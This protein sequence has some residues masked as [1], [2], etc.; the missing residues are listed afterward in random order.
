M[1]CLASPA[2]L[3]QTVADGVNSAQT[4]DQTLELA[5]MSVEASAQDESPQSYTI[6]RTRGATGLDLSPRQT[7]Q[8]VTSITRQQLDDQ[9]ITTIDQALLNT[10]GITVNQ[11]DI[12]MRNSYRARGYDIA[13]YRVDGLAFEGA[14][15]IS[16]SGTAIN[17]DLYE[18]IDIVRG[19]NGLL[20]GTGDP[21]ATIDLQRKR[22]TRDFG[23]SASLTYG[24]W[25]QKRV[26]GDINLPLSVDGS[27]RSRLVVS[28]EESDGFLDHQSNRSHG[29]LLNFEL[30]LSDRT[31]LGA[32]LQYEYN[33][34]AGATWG[35]NS[36]V[37]FSDGSMTKVSR[38]T[39]VVPSWSS[40]EVESRTLFASLQHAFE[41][42]WQA[43]LKLSRTDS[44]VANDI[45]IAKVNQIR[46]AT[47]GG[48]WN[49]DGSGAYMNGF[50]SEPETVSETM[51][52]RFTGPFELL[53]REHQ[54]MIGYNSTWTTETSPQFDCSFGGVSSG[55]TTC[56]WRVNPG[57]RL[58]VPDWRNWNGDMERISAN[59]TGHDT[60]TKTQLRGTWLATRLSITDPLSVVL[61]ARL[62]TY[63]T[64]KETESFSGTARS[65]Q[66]RESDVLTPYAGIVYD[67]NDTYSL[68]A[69][70]TDVFTPQ[71][72]VTASGN[73]VEPI[74]GK[75]YETGIKGEWFDGRLNA[76]LATFKTKQDNLAVDDY[77]ALTPEGN[78]AKKAG[79]GV[80]TRGF[81]LEMAGAITP[82]WSVFAGYT[83]LDYKPVD[84]SE[85]TRD[86]PRHAIRLST[87]YQLPNQWN[88]LAI[89]GGMSA[90]SSKNVRSGPAGE[91]TNRDG[92]SQRNMT[93]LTHS[94]Y[95]LF[96]LM[97]D[98][99]ITD[100]TSLALNVSNLFDKHYYRNYGFYAGK[101]YGEPRR[102][103]L[104][105][106][107]T[108]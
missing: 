100:N 56:I 93:D 49:V 39:N 94:G 54:A 103:T 52:L 8:S 102:T 99:Q 1:S 9:G 7:P 15:D 105:L 57:S 72:A 5:P 58:A 31:T 82:D 86:D 76:S 69:S 68:Y 55:G 36:P 29:A 89:G 73:F 47:Y 11:L 87:R 26:V 20:G 46:G 10:T 33:K 16:G 92:T 81:E 85:S 97:G 106:R 14:S 67:L 79:S 32:G 22:P 70:Y 107:T 23:G 12:G 96:H 28:N 66:Q 17:L 95:A 63:R 13:N 19:A 71:T 101:I 98:Y 27:L 24:S 74:V 91:P 51:D 44:E 48:Y 3:A 88:R 45:A 80:E 59:K 108:F 34:V 40:R 78:D 37:W 6:K 53:G 25:N 60:T 75:S 83:Y 50:Y 18:R 64:Y 35:A 41:N 62:T 90:Q 77:G 61:G 38:K 2:L 43:D 104:T 21:S 30:D 65:A 42:E 4:S 84:S